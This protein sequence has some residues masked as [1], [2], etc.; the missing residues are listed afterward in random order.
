MRSK[1]KAVAIVIEGLRNGGSER[2]ASILANSWASQGRPVDVITMSGVEDDFFQLDPAVQRNVIRGRKN[3]ISF[4]QGLKINIHRIRSFRQALTRS[5]ASTVI[6][7]NLVVNILV[8]LAG[9]GLGRRIIIS[10]RTD[11]NRQDMGRVWALLRKLLYHRAHTVTANSRHAIQVM[12]SYVPRHRLSLIPNPVKQQKNTV[13]MEDK[14]KSILMVG[15][16]VPLKR[17]SLALEAFALS[18]DQKRDWKLVFVG[19]GPDRAGLED[20]AR[21]LDIA[22]QVIFAGNV[23]DPGS[24]YKAA[25]IF[26]LT[27]SHEGLSNALLEA[28]S[29]QIPSIVS[30]GLPGA[31][32]Y[33]EEARTGLVFRAGDSTHLAQRLEQL[34]TNFD[35]R[36]QL[37]SAARQRIKELKIDR[38]LALWERMI[39]GDQ[40]ERGPS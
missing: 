21:K 25:S 11:P 40:E 34:M 28:M 16:M 10:E 9:T 19:D 31:L 29:W 24:Y 20:T 38:I 36:K 1:N 17:Q 5:Q 8:I 3:A 26:L 39:E 33:V 13:A 15:R 7:F 30:D 37:G 35:M 18:G 12:A 22:N 6:S 4:W 27:S 32:E 14:E 23:E 2:V